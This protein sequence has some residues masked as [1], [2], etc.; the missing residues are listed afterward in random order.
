MSFNVEKFLEDAKTGLALGNSVLP[1]LGDSPQANLGRGY[2]EALRDVIE[3]I[4]SG[5]YDD[6]DD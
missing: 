5:E 3:S 4:E 1:F 6:G 2:S